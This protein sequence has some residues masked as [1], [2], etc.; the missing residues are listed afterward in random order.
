MEFKRAT[1]ETCAEATDTVVV[2]D[3][4][5]AFS[6]AAFAFAAGAEEI[7]LVQEAADAFALQQK[8]PDALL[9]GE[10]DGLPIEGFDYGNSPSAL[11]NLRL[12]GRHFIQRTSR[13]TLGVVRSTRANIILAGSFC[14]AKATANHILKRAP[15][16]VTFVVTGL[17]QNGM[18]DED[19]ACADYLES[20]LRG[21]Q[22]DPEPFLK[23]VGESVIGQLI[24]D[25]TRP[26]FPEDDLPCCTDLDRLDAAML[27]TRQ[28]GLLVMKPA[29]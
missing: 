17:G 6:C 5:R 13:G 24:L 26:E 21:R 10:V 15:D 18:G 14:C 11:K 19:I 22:P 7:I 25:P 28:N 3:V 29:R 2:I 16:T 1:L 8:I 27:V 23:R 9:M 4:L 20:L 12:T